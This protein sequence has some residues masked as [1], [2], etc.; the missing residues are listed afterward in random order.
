MEQSLKIVEISRK[1]VFRF[2]ENPL[3]TGNI[4]RNIRNES[5]G[6]RKRPGRLRVLLLLSCFP[7]V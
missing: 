4:K 2:S 5:K 6:R 7:L 3:K 1:I